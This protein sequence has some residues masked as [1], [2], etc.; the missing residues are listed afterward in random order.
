[1]EKNPESSVTKNQE[2]EFHQ[3]I[4]NSLESHSP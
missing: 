1:M 2:N 3:F 4:K